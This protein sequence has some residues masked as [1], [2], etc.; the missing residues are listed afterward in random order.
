MYIDKEGNKWYKGNLHTHTTLSDGRE[1]PEN[2]IRLYR[3]N[4]YDFIAVTDHWKFFEGAESEGF[5]VLSG[6]ELD[7]TAGGIFHIVGI[8]ADKMPAAEKTFSAQALIDSILEQNGIAILAHPAW[9]LNQPEAIAALR[10][11]SG[12]E[13]YNSV[14]GYPYSARP[15]SGTLLDLACVRGFRAPLV[16]ADDTHYYQEDLFRGFVYVKAKECTRR[17]ILRAL[18]QGDFYAS[19]GPRVS[20]QVKDGYYTVFT[21]SDT[22]Y[23]QFFS[24]SAWQPDTTC[25]PE[26]GKALSE[27]RFRIKPG[28][29]FVRAEVRAKN[30]AR[31]YTHY[32]WI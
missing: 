30:G 11:L 28:D 14:S 7:T 12:A 10:G 27:A 15:Y 6:T 23:V 26:P 5:S 31:A 21:E 2:A 24:G 16:A 17:E 19:Q 22:E 9:S 13:I 8:G 18:K 25:R 20:S 4:G 1:S 3:D 29:R 32:H